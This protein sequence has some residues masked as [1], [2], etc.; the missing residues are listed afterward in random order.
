MI[1]V[2]QH[3]Q[4]GGVTNDTANAWPWPNFSRAE[5]ACRCCGQGYYWPE[6]MARLQMAR[7]LIG[8]PLKI[9]S[10]HRCGLHNARVGGAPL[11]QHLKLAAD[12]SLAGHDRHALYLACRDA[13]FSG[14]GFA[15]TFLHV[16]L[17]RKR[18]WYYG[19]RSK[20]LWRT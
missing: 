13:G 20:A 19:E 3:T 5:M 11:S 10:A 6:F 2:L 14:F 8:A 12:M 18:F 17:G 7:D 4:S 16:D 1:S 15:Q 9:N